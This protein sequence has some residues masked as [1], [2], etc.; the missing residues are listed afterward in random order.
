MLRSHIGDIFIYTYFSSPANSLAYIL[1]SHT[2]LQ[3]VLYKCLFRY[4][5]S[6]ACS[7]LNKAASIPPPK[8]NMIPYKKKGGP[9]LRSSNPWALGQCAWLPQR[10]SVPI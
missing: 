6:K 4:I 8:K 7:Q 1:S 5:S 2:Y 9:T 10:V 3:N